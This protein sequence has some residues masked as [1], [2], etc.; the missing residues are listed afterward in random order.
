MGHV[1]HERGVLGRIILVTV[2]LGMAFI[3]LAGN[4]TRLHLGNHS[5]VGKH[6]FS[7]A[8]VAKR[9]DIYSRDGKQSSP[10][11]RDLL[12]YH[13]YLDPVSVATNRNH[14]PEKI[15]KVI[16]AHLP[17]SEEEALAKFSDKTS[18]GRVN[19]HNKLGF[20]YDSS[21]VAALIT[22][23]VSGIS[24]KTVPVRINPQGARMA[25]VL[26][27]VNSLGVASGGVEAYYNEQLKGTDGEIV[28]VLDAKQREIYHK[29]KQH[30]LPV[31]GND[32]F[33]TIDNNIQYAAECEL[34]NVV[35]AYDAL[36]AWIIVQHVQ[37]GAI[38]AMASVDA[39]VGKE[40]AE[41]NEEYWRNKAISVSYEPGSVMK[42]L[43]VAAALNEGII[44]TDTLFDV[45]SGIWYYRGIPLR[46]HV[47]GVISLETVLKK[48]SNIVCAQL[49]VSLGEIRFTNYMKGFNFGSRLGI[50]LPGEESGI[51]P[52]PGNKKFWDPIK[53]SR[54]PIG[55]GVSV[56]GLQMIN[57][58]SMLANQGLLLKPYIV[59]KIV[60]PEGEV[61]YK[62]QPTVI[63]RPIRPEVA[64]DVCKMLQSVTEHD[65]TGSRAAISG[66]STAGKTGTAQKAG[67]GG[68]STTDYYAS[69]VGF[70]PVSKPVFSVLV[71]VDRPR[72]QH[73]GSKI[74]APIF[75]KIA[76]VTARRLEVE[77]D[78]LTDEMIR[79]SR[80]GVARISGN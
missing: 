37:T 80:Q 52:L 43:T 42:A 40:D 12:S 65:G 3:G 59:A 35:E 15:A 8:L 39:G 64:R 34:K 22:N 24:Y 51:L 32:V 60:S 16:A 57:A 73:T 45:G 28:G 13:F 21:V 27:F 77:P 26:G 47:T 79:E 19:R 4:L 66:Y 67:K 44:K 17:L 25:P 55:Q 49:G 30:I 61:I 78:M 29:R 63:G 38:L 11:A 75:A 50:D 46:D 56:T 14:T 72:P 7:R 10:L 70:V 2:F 6:G 48:S 62:A 20:S 41:S 74:A 33:L 71:S 1:M 18:F 31:A 68:Y 69:F 9:G 23:T 76:S 53:I 5:K 36:G 58:Y 54:M